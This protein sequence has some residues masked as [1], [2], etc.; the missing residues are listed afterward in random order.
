MPATSE[1]VELYDEIATTLPNDEKA[2][3]ALFCKALILKDSRDYKDSIE[4]ALT[5]IRRYPKDPLAAASYLVI[6]VNYYHLNRC[7]PDNPD[8]LAMALINIRRFGQEFPGDGRVNEAMNIYCQ[9]E[10]HHAN[11]LFEMGCFY[12][13]TNHCNAAI[14]YYMKAAREFPETKAA[15]KA[16]E[17]LRMF[18]PS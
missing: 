2:P 10:E 7:E 16:R 15:A 4:T 11:A 5:L 1:A 18:Y 3:H 9:M 13:R 17:H 8:L 14:I 12:Q 6:A